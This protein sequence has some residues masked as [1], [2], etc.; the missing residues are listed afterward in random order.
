MLPRTTILLVEMATEKSRRPSLVVL[1]I[2]PAGPG[3]GRNV[4][5]TYISYEQAFPLT[6]S[7]SQLIDSSTGTP[8]ALV[9]P[10]CQ[11]CLTARHDTDHLDT[12]IVRRA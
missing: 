9:Y 2:F 8:L 12:H 4:V 7:K 5:V 1:S 6:A 11:S 3:R 10:S